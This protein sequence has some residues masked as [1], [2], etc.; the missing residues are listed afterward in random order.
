MIRP[1]YPYPMQAYQSNAVSIP[2]DEF[3][4]TFLTIQELLAHDADPGEFIVDDPF[5]STAS[6]VKVDLRKHLQN[7]HDRMSEIKQ[8]VTS[9][10][11]MITIDFD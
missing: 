7:L 6:S 11:R 5:F 1:N 2:R 9:S 10:T 4:E 8:S 3:N